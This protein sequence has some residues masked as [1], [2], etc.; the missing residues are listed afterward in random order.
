VD[1]R[2]LVI[3]EQRDVADRVPG[4]PAVEALGP[5]PSGAACGALGRRQAPA[6][7]LLAIRF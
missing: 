6:F 5:R 1:S 4:L 2:E 7:G 3:A